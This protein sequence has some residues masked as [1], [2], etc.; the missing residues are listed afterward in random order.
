MTF[1][2]SETSFTITFS[3]TAPCW[4]GILPRPHGTYLWMTTVEAGT[5]TTYHAS[6]P[7][8]VRIGAP[9]YVRV[10][11]NGVRLALPPKMIQPYD[12]TFTVGSSISA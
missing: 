8:Y 4:I 7:V 11:V 9:Q 10:K 5:T 2:L 3:A 12:V 6:A 1:P